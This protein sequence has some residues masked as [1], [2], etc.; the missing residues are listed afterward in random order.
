MV[1]WRMLT[2]EVVNND[3]TTLYKWYR[4]LKI[5]FGNPERRAVGRIFRNIIQ[6]NFFSV[7]ILIPAPILNTVYTYMVDAIR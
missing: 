3:R 7:V 2:V 6:A 1:V 5:F 4:T